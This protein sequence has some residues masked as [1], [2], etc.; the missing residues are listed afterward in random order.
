MH[1]LPGGIEWIIILFVG[2]FV[3]IVPLAFIVFVVV[4]LLKINS[5]LTAIKKKLDGPEQDQT[6]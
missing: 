2:T 4:S 5:T 3:Y 1:A 6:Q